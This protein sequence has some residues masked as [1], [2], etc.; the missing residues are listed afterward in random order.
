MNFENSLI[1][2]IQSVGFSKSVKEGEVFIKPGKQTAYIPFVLKGR[3]KVSRVDHDK[4]EV[5]LYY[6]EGGETCAMS[7]SCCL[8]DHKSAISVSAEEDTSLWLIPVNRLD[9]WVAKYPN[10]RK[11]VF[12]SYRIRF[13]ELL[14]AIDSMAFM[15]MDERL[16]KYLLDTKQSS[17][18]YIVSKTHE[19][20]AAELNTSRVVI[21][22]LLKKLEGEEKIELHRN[23]IEIL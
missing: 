11:F 22:R 8:N 13:D 3:L 10:F 14:G 23:K 20:I 17:G 7:I 1:E 19:E 5:F 21:S 12:N 18:S 9:E 4:G 15:K 16:F 6:L 2:E